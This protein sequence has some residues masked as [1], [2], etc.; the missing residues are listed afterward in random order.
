MIN[1]YGR[2]NMLRT[3]VLNTGTEVETASDVV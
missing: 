3:T 1:D 2:G